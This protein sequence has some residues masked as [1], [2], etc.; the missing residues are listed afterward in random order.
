MENWQ[1]ALINE[2]RRRQDQIAEADMH[3]LAQ[4]VVAQKPGWHRIYQN[5]L[6]QL[7]DLLIEAGTRL[8]CRYTELAAPSTHGTEI[9]PCS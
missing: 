5:L 2:T 8:H 6:L 9:S 4:Q 7:A 3:R 1:I